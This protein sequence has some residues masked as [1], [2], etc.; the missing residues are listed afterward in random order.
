MMKRKRILFLMFLCFGACFAAWGQQASSLTAPGLNIQI[1]TPGEDA[2][3]LGQAIRIVLLLTVLSLAPSFVILTTSFTRILVVFGFLRRALGTQSAP[4]TQVLAGLSLFL[5]I[6]IM[7]PVWKQIDK[8]AIKPYQAKELSAEKAW[9]AGFKPLRKFMASQTGETEFAL[10]VEL[11]GT[12][13]QEMEQAEMSL[14]VP[15][16]ILSE[17]KTAF[18]LGFLIYLPFLLIDL[19]TATVLMSLGMMMLPPMMVSLPIKILFFVL[20][21][22]WTVLIRG[23]LASFMG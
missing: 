14:L 22:G 3:G 15:A 23:I 16:F 12:Q 9:E 10:F 4:P 1:G 11:G 13:V 18:K 19:V 6:F 5:T 21:D 8:E 20:A 2:E 17:L 7:L